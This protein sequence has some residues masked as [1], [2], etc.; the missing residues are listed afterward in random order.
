M[1]Y[2]LNSNLRYFESNNILIKDYHILHLILSVTEQKSDYLMRLN[3][4][5][6]IEAYESTAE[7]YK[8]DGLLMQ[9]PSHQLPRR[10]P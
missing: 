6:V 4:I 5:P 7:A 8:S 3:K 1:R 2:F 9:T 10:I